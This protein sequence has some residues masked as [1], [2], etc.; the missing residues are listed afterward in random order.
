MPSFLRRRNIDMV[1][2]RSAVADDIPE[3]LALE[4]GAP[5]AAHWTHPQYEQALNDN[6]V[7]RMTL[8]ADEPKEN[9]ILGFLIASRIADDWEIEN[10]VVAEA[11]RRKHIASHL[12][13]AFLG[14]LRAGGAGSVL[15]EVRESNFGARRLYEKIGFTAEGRR[16]NYYSFPDEDAVL[17][18][19][20]LQSCDKIP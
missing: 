12:V 8:I 2:I 19:L 7:Q 17:Y 4:H 14:E 20:P 16:K 6:S 11:W 10:V 13:V 9:F 3:L 18:R 5:S 15:L 1:R